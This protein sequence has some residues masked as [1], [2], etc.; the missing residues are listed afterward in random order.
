MPVSLKYED[1]AKALAT[2]RQDPTNENNKLE[3][4][5]LIQPIIK[6]T[7][8]KFPADM[9]DDMAQE[10]RIFLMKRAEYIATQFINDKIKSPTNY[11]FRVCYNSAM[12]FIKKDKK[13]TDGLVPIDDVK[14]EP[15]Y[16]PKS[17]SKSKIVDEIRQQC[18]DFI[19]LRY[20][21][22]EDQRVAEKLLMTLLSGKRPSFMTKKLRTFAAK[23]DQNMKDIYSVVLLK[24]RELVEP[25][26][27][28]LIE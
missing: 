11:I 5:N 21:K 19:R 10:M 26:L 18:L 9:A 23:R 12:N 8:D 14:I 7:T 15:V 4:L 22:K 16:K 27:G 20:T 1:L 6:L 25:R 17:S 24:L 28:E 13:T 3:F 2:I